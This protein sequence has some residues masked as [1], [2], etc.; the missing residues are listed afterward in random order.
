VQ[1]QWIH[2]DPSDARSREHFSQMIGSNDTV[3]ILRG[4]IR[5]SQSNSAFGA[6]I[7]PDAALEEMT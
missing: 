7:F 1:W 2:S 6:V 5:N 3:D 4:S